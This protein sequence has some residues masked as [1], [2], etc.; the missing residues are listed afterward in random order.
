MPMHKADKM[1]SNARRRVFSCS[2][3]LGWII[4]PNKPS[5]GLSS[6]FRLSSTFAITSGCSAQ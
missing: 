4:Q 2:M 3:K 1:V 6:N 5:G